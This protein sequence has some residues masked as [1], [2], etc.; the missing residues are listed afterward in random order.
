MGEAQ[1]NIAAQ[2][3]LRE[4]HG[5][6]RLG[7]VDSESTGSQMWLMRLL[8]ACCFYPGSIANKVAHARGNNLSGGTT[9]LATKLVV[10]RHEKK[11][12]S[13][14]ASATLFAILC[15]RV[16]CLMCHYNLIAEI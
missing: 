16:H 2:A 10:A 3:S 8:A 4:G 15:I 9:W 11:R 12:L 14:W 6:C 1:Q 7:P 13:T 5:S